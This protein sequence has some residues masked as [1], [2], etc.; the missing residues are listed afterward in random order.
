[1]AEEKK[2]EGF[3]DAH[4]H[5]LGVFS[6]LLLIL[7]IIVAVWLFFFNNSALDGDVEEIKPIETAEDLTETKRAP[8]PEEF[9]NILG[10][11]PIGD[12]DNMLYASHDH[13][14]DGELFFDGFAYYAK[15]QTIESMK[16]AWREYA[17][18][19]NWSFVEEDDLRIVF[20]NEIGE[21]VYVNF[22]EDIIEVGGET[23][24]NLFV[25]VEFGMTD[26][27]TAD[28]EI[29]EEEPVQ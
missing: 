4:E 25:T 28:G 19:E 29:P 23:R 10:D 2:K 5:E 3:N 8:T 16:E 22:E 13:T 11:Y 12:D 27:R 26:F 14:E 7:L 9:K 18:G 15:D 17:D 20:E 6:W 24:N 1:M 21:M